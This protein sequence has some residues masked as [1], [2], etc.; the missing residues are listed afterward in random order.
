MVETFN[1]IAAENQ[2]LIDWIRVLLPECRRVP[3]GG[4]EWD[5]LLVRLDACRNLPVRYQPET[6]RDADS[7]G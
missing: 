1:R 5:T 2:A 4:A 6:W 7:N 3:A